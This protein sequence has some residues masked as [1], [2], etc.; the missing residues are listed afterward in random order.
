MK[1]ITLKR[2]EVVLGMMFLFLVQGIKAQF[3]ETI[4][5]NRPGA[6]VNVFTVGKDVF[7]VEAGVDFK[8][9]DSLNTSSILLK[10]GLSEKI[11]INAGIARTFSNNILQPQEIYS[12]GVKYNIFKGDDMLPSTG[13][14]ISFNL[15]N[16]KGVN[17]IPESVKVNSYT[18]LLFLMGFTLN[19]KWSY[20]FNFGADVDFE[21][22]VVFPGTTDEKNI[23]LIKGVYAFN[24]VYSVN[25]KMSVFVEP[26]GSLDKYDDPKIRMNFNTGVSYL[27]NNDLQLDVIAGHNKLTDNGFFSRSWYFLEI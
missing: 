25:D 22:S 16:Y 21:K 26:Y 9:V 2:K 3:Q 23:I 12:F 27:V 11:E 17:N 10:Y 6:A 13:F 18:S 1:K 7:Q 4:Q 14:Q 8:E 15:P 19:E 24:L 5:A 20:T